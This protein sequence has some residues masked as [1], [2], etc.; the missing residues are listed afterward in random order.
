MK[1]LGAG[2]GVGGVRR[3]WVP[4]FMRSGDIT[5]VQQMAMLLHASGVLDIGFKLPPPSFLE[6][7]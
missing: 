3:V 2:G 5:H 7:K 4:K 6:K 1:A